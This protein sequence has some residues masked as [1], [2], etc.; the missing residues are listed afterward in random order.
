MPVNFDHVP[1]FT[2][3]E[4]DDPNFPGS[5]RN[6]NGELLHQFVKMRIETGWPI[7]PHGSVGGV[8]DMEGRHGHAENS[9]HLA[10]NGC[11]A[12]DFHFVTDKSLREQYNWVCRY[13]FS[14]IG[15]YPQWRNPGFHVDWRPVHMTQ[16][17][18]RIDG[19]YFY[20]LKGV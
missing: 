20:L 11:S 4:F 16:H 2:E 19:Q 17:W 14:G 18:T 6:I 7:I 8:V 5:G 9:L 12:I 1:H 13:G 3:P 10:R 15:I